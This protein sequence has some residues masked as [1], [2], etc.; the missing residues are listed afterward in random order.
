MEFCNYEMKK[1]R[2]MLLK[3]YIRKSDQ[4]QRK[5]ISWQFVTTPMNKC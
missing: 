1:H 3:A 5:I 2:S 4:E